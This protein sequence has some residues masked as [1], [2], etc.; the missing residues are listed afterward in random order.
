MRYEI[1][2]YVSGELQ[3]NRTTSVITLDGKNPDLNV[4]QFTAAL[5]HNVSTSH[6]ILSAPTAEI[7]DLIF[8]GASLGQK[9]LHQLSIQGLLSTEAFSRLC[10]LL[11]DRAND[12]DFVLGIG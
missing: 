7:L 8:R 2:D 10:E 3:A 1:S 11:Q 4:E 12:L 9:K 5:T 6:L